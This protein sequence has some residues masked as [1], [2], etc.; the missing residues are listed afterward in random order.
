MWNPGW[1]VVVMVMKIGDPVYHN[2]DELLILF[3]NSIRF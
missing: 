1:M 3:G 2:L